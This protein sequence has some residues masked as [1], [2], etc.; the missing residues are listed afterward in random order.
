[1]AGRVGKEDIAYKLA[2]EGF[3]GAGEAC[4]NSP[5]LIQSYFPVL[6]RLVFNSNMA[7]QSNPI[8]YKRPSQ[9]V[10]RH[11]ES[12]GDLGVCRRCVPSS[13]LGWK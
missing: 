8:S 5:V 1:M 6:N 9:E 7:A 4:L 12:H 2:D 13:R 11:A 3:L 10:F